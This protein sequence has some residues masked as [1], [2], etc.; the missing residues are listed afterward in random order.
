MANWKKEDQTYIK[1]YAPSRTL[2]ELVERFER[3]ESDVVA[4]L[5]EMKIA[6]KDGHG[7][8]ARFVDPS[9]EHYEKGLEPFHK[10]QWGEAK[11]HFEK[12][13]EQSEQ[14]DLT[15]RARLFISMCDENLAGPEKL[16]D[17]FLEAV[18]AKNEGNLEAA[19]ELCNL[20]DRRSSDDRFAYLAASVKALEGAHQAAMD[21]LKNAIALNPTNRIQAF[22][23]PD[24]ESMRDSS[25]FRELFESA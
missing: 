7:F 3:P 14:N 10:G 16:D 17:P 12:V 6:S 1:R 13:V 8:K 9:V 20:N 4:K 21:L 22:H 23:D 15:A 2:A 25:E 18:I 5:L 11:K 24:F 19:S